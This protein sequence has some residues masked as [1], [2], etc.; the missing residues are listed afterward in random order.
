MDFS[1]VN[2]NAYGTTDSDQTDTNIL[3]VFE[4]S[5]SLTELMQAIAC[6]FVS[7]MVAM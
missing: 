3:P 1:C 6:D 5:Q 7:E 4:Q 2:Q